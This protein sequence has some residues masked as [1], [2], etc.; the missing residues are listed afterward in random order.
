MSISQ[1]IAEIQPEVS[2][3]HHASN[4]LLWYAK[5]VLSIDTKSITFGQHSLKMKLF[6]FCENRSNGLGGVFEKVGFQHRSKWQT[7]ILADNGKIGYH[8]SQHDP[9][10]LLIQSHYNRQNSQKA[11]S[12]YLTFHRKF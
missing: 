10:N 8:C 4:S 3:W 1:S 12:I 6:D 9:R 7:R 5:T 2:F 11:I